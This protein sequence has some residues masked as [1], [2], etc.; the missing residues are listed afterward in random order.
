MQSWRDLLQLSGYLHDSL[1]PLEAVVEQDTKH[2]A[3]Q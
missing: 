3:L 2:P 1:Y